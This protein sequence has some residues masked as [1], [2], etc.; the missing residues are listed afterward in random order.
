MLPLAFGAHAGSLLA[1][2]GT[3][4]KLI[5]SD[6]AEQAGVGSFGFFE[7]ALVGLPLTAGVIA[8]A[9]LFG[10]RLLPERHPRSIAPDF[11]DHARTLIAQYELDHAADEL[12]TRRQGVAEVVI[13]PRSA[14][15]GDRVFPGMITES[16]DLAI[17]AVQ[18]R[19]D[20]TGPGETLLAEGDTLL[21]QGTWAALDANLHASEVLVVD[22]PEQVRRQAVPLG[23]GARAALIVLAGMVLALATG[24]VPP[25]VAGLVAA[26]AMV[27][28]GV[29]TVEQAQRGISWTTVVLVGGM[30]SLSTAMV[31]SGAAELLADRLVDVVGDAGP[32][33][34][35]LGLFLLTAVLGQLISNM[36]TALIVIPIAISAAAEMDVSAKPVLMAVTVSAAA[37]FLTPVAT[38]ANL[39]VMEPGEYRFGDYWK[40]GLPMLVLF[41]VVAVLLV[42][43]FWA[44]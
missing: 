38:P 10:E 11:S 34:L 39:M 19:G 20:D 40:L 9:V 23:A 27:L 7:F 15:A 43:V 26:G 29:L 17:L 37:S 3:P 5:V 28:S 31:S 35:L 21:L 22:P 44:L 14:L 13:P 42:P 30:I 6:A 33:A 18:R 41:G 2:S 8:I 32:H 12:M 24:V 25:A 1:L 16:G 36:A 4:G